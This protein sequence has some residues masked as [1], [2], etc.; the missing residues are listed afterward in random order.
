MNSRVCGAALGALLGFTSWTSEAA[1]LMRARVDTEVHWPDAEVTLTVDPSFLLLPFAEEALEN[2]LLTWQTN[3]PHLPRVHIKYPDLAHPEPR[4]A[5]GNRISLAMGYDPNLNEAL[6][7]TMVTRDSSTGVIYDADIIVS[8]FYAFWDLAGVAPGGCGDSERDDW[9]SPHDPLHGPVYDL[10]NVL[11]HELG[12]WFG[13]PEDYVDAERTMFAYVNPGE[14]TKRDL[15]E[16]DII[17]AIEI[18][19]NASF[20]STEGASCSVSRPTS[21]PRWLIVMGTALVLCGMHRRGRTVWDT[22][23]RPSAPGPAS[24]KRDT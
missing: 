19:E 6:A 12:H 20:G 7:I 14:L 9:D 8:P 24:L 3:V 13:L 5:K 17:M 22:S 11:T 18:Y 10:Q 4:D 16:L 23:A 2:A 1:D 15:A 21:S